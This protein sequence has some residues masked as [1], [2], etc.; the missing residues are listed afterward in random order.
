MSLTN[1][2]ERLRLFENIL[3]EPNG[4]NTMH[5][6]KMKVVGRSATALAI[7][8]T[9]TVGSASLASASGHHDHGNK[10]RDVASGKVSS[11]DYAKVGQGGYVTA[12]TMSSVTVLLWSGTTTTY[13]LTGTTQYTEGK[14]PSSITSLVTGDRVNVQTSSTD[15]TTALSVNIE[16]AELFGKV[17]AVSGESITITDPQG[18]SRTILASMATT[19]T[20]GGAPGKLADVIVGSKIVADGTIDTNLTTLDALSIKVST[21]G[22][23]STM[24]TIR[25]VVTAFT[26]PSLTVLAKD[27]TSTVFTLSTTTTFKDDGVSLSAADLA[28]GSKVGVEVSSAAATT[29]LN[30]EIELAHLSGTV[31]AISGNTITIGDH[32][33]S[34]RTILVGTTTY[35]K[36]GAPATLADVVVGARISGEGTL[37]VDGL[38]LTAISVAIKKVVVLT[39]TPEPQKN[40]HHDNDGSSGNSGSGGHSGSGRNH[41]HGGRGHNR[42]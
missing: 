27:G 33:G 37:S 36:D 39:P 38:T 26:S 3:N 2:I 31:T 10:N 25:G 7:G 42:H 20:T 17:T 29:A 15:P 22:T 23:A 11:F 28:V 41:G 16:L 5:T 30:V 19:F 8:M 9:L 4:G 21:V 32:Q 1:L 12:V 6:R 14:S 40:G 13:A 35:T 34:P 18:F 24:D